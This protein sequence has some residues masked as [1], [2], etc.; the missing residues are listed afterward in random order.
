MS[1]EHDCARP[2]AFPA[3]VFNRPGLARFAY[4]IGH[5]PTMRAHMLDRLVEAP[6]L[7]GWTHLGSDDPGIA[8]LDAAATV[9]DVLTFYQELYANETK[10]GTAAR[11]DS[12]R[13][14]IRL[15]G[16]RPAP[17]LG[18]AAVFAAAVDGAGPVTIPAG[19]PFE[20]LLDGFEKPSKFESADRA[21]AWPAFGSFRLYRPRL[22]PQ[23]I[24]RGLTA[25]DLVRLGGAEDLA[26]RAAVEL[27]PGDRIM[28][29]PAHADIRQPAEILVV[30]SVETKLDRVTIAFEGALARARPATM[31]AWKLG[32]TFRHHG[33]EAAREYTTFTDSPPTVTQHTTSLVRWIS[34]DVV[35][36][37]GHYSELLAAEMPLDSEVDDLAAGAKLI[38]TG[39]GTDWSTFAPAPFTVVRE[40][41]QV[42]ARTVTWGNT[43]AAVSVVT[44]DDILIPDFRLN[45]L[46]HDIRNLR[47]HETLGP[48]MRLA[49]PPPPEPGP[50]PDARLSYFGT[51]AEAAALA[52]RTL[53]LVNG[54]KTEQVQVSE[55]FA[56][57]LPAPADDRR[58]W[59]ITLTAIPQA[60]RAAF[61]E[62]APAITVHGN[63]VP[64]TEGVTQ[65]AAVLG[66]G[67]AR[68]AFQ[69]FALPKA[70]LT[71]HGDPVATPPYR[72]ALEVR[73]TGRRWNPVDSFFGQPP[74]AQVYVIRQD[75]AGKDVVQFG[76]GV[77]GARLPSG[78]GNVTATYRTG[79]GAHGPLAPG[80]EAKGKGKLKPLK[81]VL[82][83]GPVTGGADPE[84]AATAR[85][86]APARMQSLGRLVGLPDY[87]AEALALP[88]VLKAGAAF[89]AVDN[90]PLI[91]VTVLTEDE[92]PEAVATVQ[93]ALRAANACRGPRRHALLV[94]PGRR[95]WV[96]L[97]LELGYDPALLPA[98]LEPALHVALGA[99]PAL[100]DAPP[101]A[102]VFALP[103]RR[104]GQDAHVSQAIA[105]AQGVPGV[106]WV[107]ATRFHRLTAPSGPPVLDPADL[108]LPPSA[109]LT[110]RIGAAPAEVLALSAHHLTLAFVAET[111][112]A[113]CA[114]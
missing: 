1:C 95:A 102:G 74:D 46:T 32:R 55:D 107:R 61:D 114:P 50:F 90:A 11:D 85:A 20:A 111:S 113:E 48:E 99:Q 51:H 49:A 41:A 68:A 96:A 58:M 16:Y 18:G 73:V 54:G 22:G 43:G 4:R 27:A 39:L 70:P 75:D 88:G 66:N 5:Y 19:F 37:S 15:T 31:R 87:E 112:D 63:L 80:A 65:P 81:S 14:L 109:A 10:L 101:A 13:D 69:T 84:P 62:A 23:P 6:E 33:A 72:A 104:F 35:D 38:A 91:A 64:A 2:A 92:S 52:G 8:L 93:A 79:L 53:L 108:A 7:Q 44:L 12:I 29:V 100:G 77:N 97:G 67:D 45:I 56:A 83:P 98:D 21:E 28:L 71:F 94:R 103:P 24:A 89:E 105:A 30:K 110:S 42:A 82:L 106:A 3:T 25:L 78:I 34:L 47:L 26:T 76:D 59:P 86:A 17:G 60:D 9:G 40:V 57:A 36:S